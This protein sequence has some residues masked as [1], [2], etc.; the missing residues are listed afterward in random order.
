MFAARLTTYPSRRTLLILPPTVGPPSSTVTANPRW[1]SRNAAVSPVIPAPTTIARSVGTGKNAGSAIDTPSRHW[2]VGSRALLSIAVWFSVQPPEVTECRNNGS[3]SSA[4]ARPASRRRS[5][6]HLCRHAAAGRR[7]GRAAGDPAARRGDRR[8]A[9]RAGAPDRPAQPVDLP[10]RAAHPGQGQGGTVATRPG[11]GPGVPL[12]QLP[13]PGQRGP[14]RHPDGAQLLRRA[15]S[16]LG[17]GEPAGTDHPG[18]AAHRAGADL[19]GRSFRRLPEPAGG[20]PPADP[21]GRR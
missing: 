21:P 4:P 12:D 2:V 18:A 11:P 3:S 19:G 7:A 13:G 20:R 6:L 10:G 14:V 17:P 16:G 15:L 8:A 5:A 9:R 1:R